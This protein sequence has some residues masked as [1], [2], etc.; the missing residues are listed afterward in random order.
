MPDYA[1]GDWGVN[2][3]ERVWDLLEISFLRKAKEGID[4]AY[5]T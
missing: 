5:K 4:P 2:Q 3:V 1:W